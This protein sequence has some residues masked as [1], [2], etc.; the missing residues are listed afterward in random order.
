MPKLG[1]SEAEAID[2]TRARWPAA[3]PKFPKR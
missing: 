3:K 2:A 1:L